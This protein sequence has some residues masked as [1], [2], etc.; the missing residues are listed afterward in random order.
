MYIFV[1][2]SFDCTT[3]FMVNK[4]EYNLTVNFIYSHCLF[5]AGIDSLLASDW[6]RLEELAS[7]LEPFAAQTDILQRDAQALSS[8]IPA[9]LDLECH[10]QQHAAPKTLTSAML[11][12]L[13]HRFGSVML[14]TAEDFNPLPAAACLLDPSLARVL[15]APDQAAVLHA[16]KSYIMQECDNSGG[17]TSSSSASSVPSD[18]DQPASSSALSRFRFLSSKMKAQERVVSSAVH[19]PHAAATQLARYLTEAADAESAVD[20]LD[21]WAARRS[22]YS[23]ISPLAED[24]LAAPASQAFVERIFSLC[25]LLS[26][27]RRNRMD[28]SLQ[29]RAF[30]KLN[31]HIC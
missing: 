14:P 31:K 21:F 25:G 13:R 5:C 30:L 3:V 2:F 1:S 8:I 9:L 4:D 15:M 27:G 18:G 17:G 22:M 10:L 23:T 16:A 12:D 29:M 28:K 24:L 20:P 6:A 11:R 7:L 26:A 19:S